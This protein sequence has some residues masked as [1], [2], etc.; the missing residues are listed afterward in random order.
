M[1]GCFT[2]QY[3]DF[4]A[5]LSSKQQLLGKLYGIKNTPEGKLD[6]NG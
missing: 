6:K 4:S 5:I 3:C 2:Q 1:I